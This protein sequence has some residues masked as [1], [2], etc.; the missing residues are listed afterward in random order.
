MTMTQTILYPLNRQ[1][2]FILIIVLSVLSP[3]SLICNLMRTRRHGTSIPTMVHHHWA[4]LDNDPLFFELDHVFN[5]KQ[6]PPQEHPEDN[7]T[8][9]TPSPPPYKYQFPPAF[10]E[11]PAILNAYIRA[12]IMSVY[13]GTTHA[14]IQSHLDGVFIAL[15]STENPPDGLDRMAWTLNTAEKCLGV[16]L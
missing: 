16:S 8:Y 14:T 9:R 7:C 10:E 13:Q 15:S 4:D 2:G 1:A 12:F 11:H 5:V 3:S 6:P